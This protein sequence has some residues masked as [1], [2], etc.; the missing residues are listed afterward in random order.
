MK[1]ETDDGFSIIE[2]K[3]SDNIIHLRDSF[4]GDTISMTSKCWHELMI[5]VNEKL[6]QGE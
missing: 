4:D 6:E 2:V 3:V 1:T 5:A